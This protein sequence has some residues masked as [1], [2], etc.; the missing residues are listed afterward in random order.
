MGTS[1][2]DLLAPAE[3]EPVRLDPVTEDDEPVRLGHDPQRLIGLELSFDER[4]A[5]CGRR[6]GFP[7]DQT[8]RGFNPPISR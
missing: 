8:S 4:R 6:P 2:L 5:R 7:N 3:C 1:N